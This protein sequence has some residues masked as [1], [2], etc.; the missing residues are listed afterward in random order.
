MTK[1]LLIVFVCSCVKTLQGAISSLRQVSHSDENG[2][3]EKE[4]DCLCVA[5]LQG[6]P[7]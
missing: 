1:T 6:A 2:D 7:G 5:R 3:D 4:L